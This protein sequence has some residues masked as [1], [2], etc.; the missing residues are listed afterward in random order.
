MREMFQFGSQR[1]AEDRKS[2]EGGMFSP[3]I[4]WANPK[5]YPKGP[6]SS[7]SASPVW[8]RIPAHTDRTG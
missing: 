5:H 4:Y 7:G 6:C 3:R 2:Q 8:Y 1:V